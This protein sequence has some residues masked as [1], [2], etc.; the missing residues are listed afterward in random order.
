MPTELQRGYESRWRDGRYMFM[1]SRYATFSAMIF[2]H[3]HLRYALNGNNRLAELGCG[4]GRDSLFFAQHGEALRA[5]EPGYAP[6]DIIACDISETARQKTRQAFE[7]QG[8]AERLDLRGDYNEL[9]DLPGSSL[10]ALYGCSSLHYQRPDK[11]AWTLFS[12]RHLLKTEGL[13]AVATKTRQASWYE[14]FQAEG[15]TPDASFDVRSLPVFW[16]PFHE[17]DPFI[18]GYLHTD[19]GIGEKAPA[20]MRWYYTSEQFQALV[21]AAG[22]IPI[23]R[24]FTCVRDYDRPG[25]H[26]GFVYVVAA[27]GNSSPFL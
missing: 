24:S 2:W 12:L 20:I 26:E 4:N 27:P 23:A 9:S 14:E 13:L 22:F 19:E 5:T 1:N 7:E 16:K 3:K 21:E 10:L 18:H 6:L 25:K 15:S 8:L 11:L 17:K